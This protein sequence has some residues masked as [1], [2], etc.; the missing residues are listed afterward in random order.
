MMTPAQLIFR[1]ILVGVGAAAI[2]DV[3]AVIAEALFAIPQSNFAMVGRW[4]GHMPQ[5]SFSHDSIRAAAPI[6][7]EAT[8]G[9]AVHYLVGVIFAAF[10]VGVGGQRQ[11]RQPNVVIALMIGVGTIVF[12]FFLMQPA[13]G[14]GV[15]ASNR[16]DP[17]FAQLKSLMSHLSFGVGLYVAAW[18]QATLLP[19]GRPQLKDV[20]G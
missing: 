12:P 18:L 8:L 2:M 20:A 13:M 4:L 6:T 17:T 3:W 11:L 19:P 5:G 9:W 7:G 16:P 15:M 14:A 1:V 10:Y